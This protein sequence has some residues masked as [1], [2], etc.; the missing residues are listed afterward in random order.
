M[1]WSIVVTSNVP[2]D[3]AD[4]ERILAVEGADSD[5]DQTLRGRQFLGALALLVALHRK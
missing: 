5:F 1:P 2:L 3:I 4:V